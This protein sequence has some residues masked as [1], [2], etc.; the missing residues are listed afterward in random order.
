VALLNNDIEVISPTWL[1]E[2]VSHAQRP[3]IGCVG[4][5]L[6][7]PD[8]RVQHAGVIVGLGGC[9]GHS[10]K[11]YKRGSKGYNDRLI[12]T[13]NYSAVTAACLVVEK[14]IFNQVHG[15]NEV[16][17]AVAF[18]DVDFCLRVNALGYRNLWTPFA[19]LYH[20]ESLS[21]GE[22][23]TR[24]KRKRLT[25]EVNYMKETWSTTTKTDP[26]Y[27]KFLTRIREDFT[28]GL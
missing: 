28:L 15:L 7:Y 25:S 2:M 23:N 20:Y 14:T 6:Y 22:D 17:L 5:M 10:H 21:R 19:E 16:E 18:N 12:C 1:T 26:F 27:S 3:D 4:A 8:N 9:A 24:S 11:F 13:Q